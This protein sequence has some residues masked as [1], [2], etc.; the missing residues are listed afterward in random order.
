MIL[1]GMDFET[2][3]LDR[4]ADRIIEVGLILYSTGQKKCLESSGYL[5][6]S[7]VPVSERITQLTGITQA[8]VNK[9]GY[10][11]RNALESFLDLADQAEA[12]VGQNI[13]QFDKLF[14]ENWCRREKLKMPEK[15]WIDTRTDLPGIES[16]HLGYMAAD[17]GFL[18][19]FPHSALSDVQTVIKLVGMHDIEKV[20]ERAK[21]PNVVLQGRQPQSD[22]E[23]AKSRKFKWNPDYKIWWKVVKQMDVDE[24]VKAAPFDVSFA[25]P[26][27]LI[28]KLWYGN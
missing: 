25:S 13:I 14:L 16:K 20:V 11:S 15:L 5:V 3:G 28:S 7:D 9:F 26:E 27:V 1:L 22:N 4:E 2:T 21:S 23:L 12:F 18:N 19:L 10:E 24:E 6:R 17:A 8:A